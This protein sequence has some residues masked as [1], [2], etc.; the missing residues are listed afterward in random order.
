MNNCASTFLLLLER[1]DTVEP[2][3][4]AGFNFE[5]QPGIAEF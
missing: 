4:E 3:S 1:M 5:P 2:V